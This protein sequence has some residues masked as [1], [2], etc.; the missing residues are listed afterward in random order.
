MKAIYLDCFAGISGNMLL[1]AFLQAGV[2]QEYLRAELEKLPLGDS[3]VM[4]VENVS[5]NGIQAVYVDVE[6]K[7]AGHK[8]EHEYHEHNEAHEHC[9]HHGHDG[10]THEHRT[11]AV[12][13][14]MIEA[15]E[16]S[17]TVKQKSLEIFTVLAEAEGKVHGRPPAEVAFHEVGAVD[18]ILDIVGTAICLD[19]LGIERVFASKVNTGSGFVQCAHGL[20]P[21]PAPAV[22]E[23]LLG[24]PIYHAGEAKE[25][26]TPTGAAVLKSQAVFF[27]SLPENFQAERVAYGAGTWEL[28]IPNVLRLYLGTMEPQE[29]QEERADGVE[30]F[31][32]LE[33][34]ID[35]M[36]PQ[37][38]GYLYDRLFAAGAA[39]VW[40]APIFMKKQR[41]AQKLSV[42]CRAERKAACVDILMRE[43]TSLGLRVMPVAERP[44]AQRKMVTVTTPYGEVRCKLAFWQGELVN[45]KPEYE[46]CCRLARTANTALKRVEEAAKLALKTIPCE[47]LR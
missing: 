1:G 16:L 17:E 32:V 24:W 18:S 6:L 22:A 31:F 19:Y 25:L 26:T 12:I 46:D 3:Y 13:R 2:P 27:E 41:P 10:H 11:F 5:K 33:T 8:H 21:V 37:I 4:K 28:S 45:A 38:Y 15:S 43:T 42:L 14:Q 9:G 36:S 30:D 23:L 29:K 34:N 40:T 47:E 35:D 20:M 39:D 7:T 44:E